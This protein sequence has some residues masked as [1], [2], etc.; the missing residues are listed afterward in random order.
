MSGNPWKAIPI[1]RCRPC[2]AL[3]K[4]DSAAPPLAKGVLRL[5]EDNVKTGLA[6]ATV[7]P[8]IEG[9]RREQGIAQVGQIKVH[10]VSADGS[11]LNGNDSVVIGLSG[12]LRS[13]R[14]RP[15][16]IAKEADIPE[17]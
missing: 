8:A 14:K 4:T 2:S 5:R 15:F 17:T 12:Q 10:R 11:V 3:C 13:R 6:L 7:R 1:S 9:T 16:K